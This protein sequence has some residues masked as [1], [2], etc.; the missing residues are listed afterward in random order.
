MYRACHESQV[1]HTASHDE[2]QNEISYPYHCHGLDS[3]HVDCGNWSVEKLLWIFL[4]REHSNRGDGP[5]SQT[6]YCMDCDICH[7]NTVLG[8]RSVKLWIGS[9]QPGVTG[10]IN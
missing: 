3:R 6:S 10:R 8:I 2:Y 4:V 1:A 9:L 7:M 5:P